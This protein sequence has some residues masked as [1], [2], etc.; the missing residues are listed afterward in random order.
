[1]IILWNSAVSG[2]KTGNYLLWSAVS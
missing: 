1:M 2:K